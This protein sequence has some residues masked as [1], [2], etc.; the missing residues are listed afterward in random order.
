M[1]VK[2]IR[3]N[4]EQSPLMNDVDGWINYANTHE[5]FCANKLDIEK[6]VEEKN[7]IVEKRYL[8][9]EISGMLKKAKHRNLRQKHRSRKRRSLPD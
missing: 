8:D 5:L 9:S 2:G 3:R 6:L 1:G 7:I 4:K